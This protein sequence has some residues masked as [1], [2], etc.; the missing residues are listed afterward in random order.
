MVLGEINLKL[1]VS[2]PTEKSNAKSLVLP[3]SLSIIHSYINFECG[4]FPLNG[5]QDNADD[6]G[7][8]IA[9]VGESTKNCEENSQYALSVIR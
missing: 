5:A 4:L 1:F 7:L 6:I 8:V 9:V 3:K 2:G